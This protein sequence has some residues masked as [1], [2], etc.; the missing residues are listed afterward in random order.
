MN[1]TSWWL[2]PRPARRLMTFALLTASLGACAPEEDAQA[3]EPVA[4]VESE[5]PAGGWRVLMPSGG[6]PIRGITRR[7]DGL[8][9]GGSSWGHGIDVWTSSNGGAS[10]SLHGSVAN[11]PNV[12]FGDVTMLAIPGTRTVFCAFREY[13]NGQFRV[14][15]TRSD[16]DGDGWVYDST[17]AGPT[18]RF[19]GAPFLFR[20]GNGDLQVYYDSELL[21][22]Q[23]GF[24]GH[25][26]IAMQGRQG[27]A[28]AWTAYGTVTVSRDKRAGALSREGMPTVVQLAGD[29]IMAVVEGVEGFP[30][31][32]ARANVIN[33]VQSWDGGRTWD[34][35][36]RRTVYSARI[37]PGSGRRYNAYVPYAIRV[38]G[39]PVGVA[40]C[41][42]EDKAGPPDL[43]SAPVDQRNCHVGFVTTTANFETWSAPSPVWT[44][45][46]R[47]YT[48]GLF[49]RAPNDVIAVIDGLGTNRVLLR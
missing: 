9:I 20:R 26:W 8:L 16:N 42:D 11:N 45:T 24:P 29:R 21:A 44:G 13:A 1:P 27:L 10:W 25:Q 5:L 4:R 3:P 18:T 31:G 6:A 12:E 48:P 43:S 34:D 47:N 28:G 36:L 41:T 30:S 40:F 32:G 2:C 49:E 35:S 14:T 38:G 23:G 22:A 33:A 46:S 39:G 7:A 17:V 37:D 19:V 15:I